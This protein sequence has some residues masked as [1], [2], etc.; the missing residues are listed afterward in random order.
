MGENPNYL[1]EIHS[2]G[3]GTREW[4]V[5]HQQAPGLG[6]TPISF[7][8]FTEARKGYEFVR[9]DPAFSVILATTAGEGEVLLNGAW[10]RCA[11][12]QA[13]VMAPRAL[14]AYHLRP[15]RRWRL[16]WV[17]YPE[18]V[19]LPAVTAGQPPRLVPVTTPGFHLA[20]EGLCYENAGKG[21]QAVV[22][23]WATIVHRM[24]LRI[25][26]SGEG[27]GRLD[28]LWLTIG[29]NIG[30]AWDLQRMARCAGMSPESLRRQCLRHCGRPPLA[31]LTHLRMLFAADLLSCTR[32]KIAA[33]AAQAGYGDAFAF[34][35]A[36]KRE[37]NMPPSRY[38][39]RQSRGG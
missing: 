37:M 13:Y 28:R 1:R 12:G 20:V 31:H 16:H 26:E 17:I 21:D 18:S 27:D 30:G 11:A 10:A 22:G 34:S 4:L 19:K 6:A 35:N 25:L 14:S 7:A 36:F 38:R 2:L 5:S 32:E 8:G 3:P 39:A 33:I 15:G 29:E 24:A 9:H 23:F